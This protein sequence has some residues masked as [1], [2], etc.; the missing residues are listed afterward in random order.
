MQ[1][2]E[3]RC[4]GGFMGLQPSIASHH[5]PVG[6]LGVVQEPA[7]TIALLFGKPLVN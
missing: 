4:L 7:Q 5:E 1:M 3:A 6:H 2:Q